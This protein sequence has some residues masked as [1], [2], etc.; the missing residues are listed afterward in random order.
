MKQKVL[1]DQYGCSNFSEVA[2]RLRIESVCGIEI[3]FQTVLT[4]GP[5][6]FLPLNLDTSANIEERTL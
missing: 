3:R 6:V 4:Q 1:L 2:R 5:P